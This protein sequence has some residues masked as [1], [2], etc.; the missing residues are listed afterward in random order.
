MVGFSPL[1]AGTLFNVTCIRFMLW[2]AAPAEPAAVSLDGN[3]GN[4]I[5]D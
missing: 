3:I 4:I 2:Q 5:A 1:F